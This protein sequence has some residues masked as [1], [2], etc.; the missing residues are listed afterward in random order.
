MKRWFCL[1]LAVLLLAALTGCNFTTNFNDSTGTTK[2]EAT[3]K[4]R[5]MMDALADGD[6]AAAEGLLHSNV[7]GE[8]KETLVQLQSFLAGRRTV[9]LEQMN[10]KVQNYTG[11]G[12]KTR[13][14]QANFQAELSDGTRFYLNVC[15]VSDDASQGF[16]S[17]QFVLGVV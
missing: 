8:K 3:D 17:F 5:Q 10:L 15:Y 7:T 2:M 11:T 14:E 13:Q 1:V 9:S 4:V 12:G 6:M 16:T